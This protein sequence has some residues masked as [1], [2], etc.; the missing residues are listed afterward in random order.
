MKCKI[1]DCGNSA[2]YKKD[3]V[4]QKHYFRFMR[5]GTYDLSQKKKLRLQNP[6]GYYKVYAPEHPLA[7][8][9]GY[10]YEHRFV[11]YN[12]KAKN[13]S[14]CELCDSSINWK[15]L[16]I[17]HVDND[18]TNNKVDNLRALC[19]GCNVFR[20]HTAESMGTLFI[21]CNGKRLTSQAWARQ[22][23]VEVAGNTIKR[24]YLSGASAHKSIYGQRKTH[25]NT[26]TKKVKTK[27]DKA[28]NI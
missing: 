18:V 3:Q 8:K 24:R 12:I 6:A 19:R 16:H 27:Y 7:N 17:D 26:V 23:G 1:K 9:D 15:S 5:T 21:E 10:V 13:V 22:K 20:G 11:F 14:N 28:R 2:V 4:C 25:H